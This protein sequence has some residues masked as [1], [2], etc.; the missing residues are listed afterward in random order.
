VA[1]LATT[2][3][4]WARSILYGALA[5]TI[6]A[7]QSEAEYFAGTAKA[8]NRSGDRDVQRKAQ[9][10]GSGRAARQRGGSGGGSGGGGSSGGGTTGVLHSPSVP[11]ATG[12]GEVVGYR[13]EGSGGGS[14]WVTVGQAFVAGDV[15]PGSGLVMDLG[16]SVVPVQMDVKALHEDGSVRHAVLTVKLPGLGSGSLDGVLKLGS[17]PSGGA[18]RG[19]DVVANGDYDVTVALDFGGSRQTVSAKEVLSEALHSGSVKSWLAGP[20][21]SEFVVSKAVNEHLTLEFAIR[22]YADGRVKTDVVVRNEATW[23][24]GIKTYSYDVEIREGGRVVASYDDLAHHQQANWHEEVWSGGAP[25]ARVIRDVDYLIASGALPAYDTD[26]GIEAAEVSNSYKKLLASDTGPL[27]K[28]TI[29]PSMNVAGGRDDIGPLPGWAV[30]YLQSQDA[31]AEA[32]L[33]ANADA[34]G[35]IPWHYRDEKTGE[36]VSIDDHPTMWLDSRQGMYAKGGDLLPTAHQNVAGWRIDTA[37]QP[38]VTYLPYLLTGSHYYLENL[39]AQAAYDLGWVNPTNRQG[40]DGILDQG[41]TRATAWSLRTLSDAAW[42]TPDGDL[43]KG[44][45]AEKLANNYDYFLG[46]AGSQTGEV[47]GYWGPNAEG[48]TATWQNDYLGQVL[49]WQA[50]RGDQGAA[51]FLAWTGQLSAGRFLNGENGFDPMYGISYKLAVIDPATGKPYASWAAVWDA[52][53]GSGGPHD[54]TYDGVTFGHNPGSGTNYVAHA[55]GSLAS[56]ISVTGAIDAI[57]AY[58]FVVG[59]SAKMDLAKDPF[60]AGIMPKLADGSY[61]KLADHKVGSAG[62]ETLTGSARSDLLNGMA[63]NDVLKGGDGSD[64]LLGDAGNDRLEGGAG[65][66]YLLGG[67]GDDV[68]LGGPGNDQLKG[69]SGRDSFVVGQGHDTIHDFD[70]RLDS[71]AIDRD[72]PPSL[73]ALLNNAASTPDSLT[74]HLDANSSITLIGV[75]LTD[76]NAGMF[77]FA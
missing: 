30:R 22:A 39:Q 32:I 54:G 6:P 3:R 51:E 16:G 13:F 24:P 69:G 68:L 61:V 25:A 18:V 53:F 31:R 40:S 28:G 43:Q 10:R 70:G 60:Y 4:S 55:R 74:L 63:G 35:S 12:S 71:I 52:T 7:C 37:H 73:A 33:F 5:L 76:L 8:Q 49:A 48:H 50:A 46:K 1:P 58:G 20:Q 57:E 27:G 17:G 72:N 47:R 2:S 44:Y 41:P 26:L 42:I 45:F 9:E 21:V 65:D 56:L 19:Q 29:Y 11:V 23:T 15:K 38:A 64:I 66:D 62:G 59:R 77:S 34:A 67:A 75:D 14:P 36:A